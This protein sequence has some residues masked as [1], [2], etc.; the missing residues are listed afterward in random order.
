[1]SEGLLHEYVAEAYH[2]ADSSPGTFEVPVFEEFR[3]RYGVPSFTG[4]HNPYPD[5]IWATRLAARHLTADD[6]GKAIWLRVIRQRHPPW[7]VVWPVG[8]VQE[9]LKVDWDILSQSMSVKLRDPRWWRRSYWMSFHADHEVIISLDPET[10]G[11]IR[12]SDP[13]GLEDYA[14]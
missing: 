7:G 2:R 4:W 1:M 13:E 12:R 9:I 6:I 3:G 14:L 10:R 11:Y 5:E 8:D